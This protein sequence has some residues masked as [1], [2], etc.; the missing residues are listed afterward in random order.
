VHGGHVSSEYGCDEL[1][2]MS[3]RSVFSP[4]HLKLGSALGDCGMHCMRGRL[5]LIGSRLRFVRDLRYRHDSECRIKLVFSDDCHQLCCGSVLGNVIC[6][7]V[8]RLLCGDLPANG[9]FDELPKLC[10]WPVP[11]IVF[12]GELPKLCIRPVCG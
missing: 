6:G 5:L 12:F 9:G 2:D 11:A 3:S 4:V 7:D 8:C 10:V 1:L